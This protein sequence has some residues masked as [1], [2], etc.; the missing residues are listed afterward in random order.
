MAGGSTR[1]I[2]C[3][4]VIERMQRHLAGQQRGVSSIPHWLAIRRSM[5]LPA[6]LVPAA[7]TST[8]TTSTSA[9]WSSA[10]SI[11]PTHARTLVVWWCSSIVVFHYACTGADRCGTHASTRVTAPIRLLPAP[12]A[13]IRLLPDP[14]RP[15]HA[16]S[17]I[18]EEEKPASQ[19]S[20]V[21]MAH[22]RRAEIFFGRHTGNARHYHA[23][24]SPSTAPRCS[25]G[26]LPLRKRASWLL[27]RA[28]AATVKKFRIE[29][30]G[31]HLKE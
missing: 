21:M 28:R 7:C 13:P 24:A 8:S 26:F 23:R 9:G 25:A 15:I 29:K 10:D 17:G 22:G 1:S 16:R 30:R 3:G 5:N 19:S 18:G 20:G 14:T 4:C 31:A 27:L 12:L 6:L 11:G 2:S